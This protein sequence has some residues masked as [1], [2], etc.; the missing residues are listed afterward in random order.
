MH[1]CIGADGGDETEEDGSIGSS[2]N[3]ADNSSKDS[4]CKDSSS[5][6]DGADADADAGHAPQTSVD[7]AN[8]PE[9]RR[10]SSIKS[11]PQTSVDPAGYLNLLVNTLDNFT[12]GLAIAGIFLSDLIIYDI[13]R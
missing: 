1:S 10:M 3:N 4:G 12:H 7:T 2:A 11:I 9:R 5:S 6:T 13:L 8:E